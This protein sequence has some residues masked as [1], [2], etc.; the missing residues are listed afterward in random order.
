MVSPIEFDH[1]RSYGPGAVREHSDAY[2]W[3]TLNDMTSD[4]NFSHM[5]EEG[6]ASGLKALFFGPQNSLLSGT[7]V[8]LDE[9]PANRDP[10]DYDFWEQN[11]YSWN[12]YKI[13][14]EQKEKTDPAFS[15]P[16]TE[17][18]PLTVSGANLPQEKQKRAK[19]IE[20]RLRERLGR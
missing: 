15:F 8:D 9:L 20:Q 2:H 17:L 4:V 12:V 5:A 11:F 6:K 10:G 13:L 18:E 19:E 7:T 14:I 1:F 16:G 3:P